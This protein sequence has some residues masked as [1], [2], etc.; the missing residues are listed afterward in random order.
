L[1]LWSG[2]KKGRGRGRGEISFLPVKG[3]EE[4]SYE[5]IV[6]RYGSLVTRSL[7]SVDTAGKKKRGG[8]KGRG[9]KGSAGCEE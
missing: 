8:G 5:A 2:L 3:G 7:L 9:G 4:A 1:N 6:K